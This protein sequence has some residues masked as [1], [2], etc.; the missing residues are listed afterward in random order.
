MPRPSRPRHLA[1][2]RWELPDGTRVPA[3]T[4]GAKKRT[5][6][7]EA[8]YAKIGGK[9]VSLG[10]SDE[11]EAWAELRRRQR[12]HADRGTDPIPEPATPATDFPTA[13]DAWIQTLLDAGGRADVIAT[14]RRRVLH[15]AELAG[16]KDV[17]DVTEASALGA[18]ARL[19]T[20]P[21]KGA[22]GGHAAFSPQT[23]NHY[24]SHLRQFAAWCVEAELLAHSPVR[25]IR[26]LSVEADQRHARR[27]PTEEEVK[28]LFDYL[29]A[30][31]ARKGMTGPQ[32]ALGY[33]VAMCAGLRLE[34]LRSLSRE[35]FD[36]EKSLVRVKAAYDKRRRVVEQPIPSWLAAELRAWFDGGG[37]CWSAF[38]RGH[39]AEV[40][41]LDLEAAGV[42]YTVPGPDGPLHFD[43]HALRVWYVSELASQP[44]ISPKTLMTLSRHST[45]ALACASTPS[46]ARRTCATPVRPCPR[47]RPNPPPRLH[48]RVSNRRT[49]RVRQFTKGQNPSS[50]RD[51]PGGGA[52]SAAAT[53]PGAS[54]VH[55]WL[56]ARVTGDEPQDG[57][58]RRVG[59]ADR[60]APE[61]RIFFSENG[62]FLRPADTACAYEIAPTVRPFATSPRCPRGDS[63]PLEGIFVDT[64]I[65]PCEDLKESG[66]G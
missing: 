57:L 23:R 36:L 4:H 7:S 28:A 14:T 10:T 19:L 40:L 56:N 25:K 58:R 32:R 42:P 44:G 5:H 63:C 12:E 61:G 9:Y 27:S 64:T 2:V 52:T 55:Y 18:L 24:L 1:V 50:V 29:A 65:V 46:P 13:V 11:A 60:I 66:R 16:W 34:E 45:P 3:G 54:P 62:V 30:A 26:K 6:Q 22:R 38:P 31:P 49:R 33:Q 21:Q 43:V 15:L 17:G 51:G 59:L 48:L 41:R 35:S 47:L 37:G 39:A 20:E 53:A 8:F